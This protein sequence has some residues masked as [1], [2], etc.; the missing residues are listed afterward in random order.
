MSEKEIRELLNDLTIQITRVSDKVEH[1]E[2]IFKDI[3]LFSLKVLAVLL[4]T[5][6]VATVGWVFLNCNK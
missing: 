3:K 2:Q 5:G 6:I 4:S 1:I